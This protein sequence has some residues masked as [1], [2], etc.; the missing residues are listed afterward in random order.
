MA[1]TSTHIPPEQFTLGIMATGYTAMAAF[2]GVDLK[3]WEHVLNPVGKRPNKTSLLIG[4]DGADWNVVLP[5]MQHGKL[6]ALAGLMEH[7]AHGNLATLDPPI[8]PMLWTSV[9]T[10]HWPS[11]HGIHGFTEVNGKTVQSVRGTSIQVPTVWDYLE[12]KGVPCSTVAWWPSH[13]AKPSKLG[14]VRISNLACSEEGKWN[15][16]GIVPEALSGLYAQLKLLPEEVLPSWMSMFFPGVALSSQEDDVLRS[17]LKILVHALNVQC[18]AT[19]AIAAGAKGHVSVYYD[20]LDHFQHLGMAFHPPQQAHVSDEQFRLYQHIVGAAYRLHDLFVGALLAQGDHDAVFVL[21]DHGFKSGSDR[22][23]NLPNHAGAPALEHRHYGLF[24]AAGKGIAQPET[25]RGLSLLDIMPTLLRFHGATVPNLPGSVRLYTNF[26]AVDLPLLSVA[27]NAAAPVVTDMEESALQKLVDLGYLEAIHLE[28]QGG[29]LLENEYYLA[30]SLRHQQNLGAAQRTVQSLMAGVRGEV[31]ERYAQL[32]AS[33]AYESQDYNALDALCTTFGAKGQSLLWSYYGVVLQL[34]R[35]EK[36]DFGPS[37]A[38]LLQNKNTGL[39]VLWG[40]LLY[41]AKEWSL[42]GQ[43]REAYAG[44]EQPDWLNLCAQYFA[45]HSQWEEALSSALAS[46]EA[47][48]FQPKMHGFIAAVLHELGHVEDAAVAQKTYESF[49]VDSALEGE[50]LYI[51]TGPPRSGTSM[52]MQILAGHGLPT[53]TSS[54]RPADENNPGGY[55]EHENVKSLHLS[56]DWLMKHRGSAIKIVGSV[57]RHLSLPPVP[58][59]V[60]IMKRAAS[61][62]AA[63]QRKM[64]GRQEVPIH[65]NEVLLWQEEEKLLHAWLKT[66]PQVHAVEVDYAA[67]VSAVEQDNWESLDGLME[68]WNQTYL[69]PFDKSVL[70]ACVKP[71]WKHF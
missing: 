21:S 10:G 33:I 2:K 39:A 64:L 71:S 51:V 43:L 53:V 70:K 37:V 7:G 38:H 40:K 20:A 6:P 30:R 3:P 52:M 55:F 14:G 32:S 61:A 67:V 23:P 27:A 58:L 17:A 41:R 56:A 9:A 4:L 69:P 34:H 68:A 35:G 29:R 31:P 54:H 25:L 28:P 13:P 36:V 5:L 57:L 60:L 24:V 11:D 42:F 66:L 65:M 49:F 44:V 16:D 59:V 8:S 62:T 63:S 22:L 48:W 18:A 26:E 19:L 45:A 15:A 47:L 12:E 46:V 1:A 50:P